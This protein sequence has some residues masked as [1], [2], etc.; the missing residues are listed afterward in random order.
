[1][2]LS[3]EDLLLEKQKLAE[4]VKEVNRQL[5]EI[6]VKV[7]DESESLK[8]FQR[9]R[10]EIDQEMDKGE[11]YSFVQENDLK[12]NILNEETLKARRLYKVKDNPYFG[13]IIFNNENL[14]IGIT[15][16]KRDMDY[17]V[18]DW[19]APISSLF[20]DYELGEATYTSP[21]GTE[22]GVITRKRQYR[23]EKGKLKH[24][25]DTNIN[26]DDEI[27]QEVLAETSSDKMKNIVNTIQAE[28]NA[29]I[30]DEKTKTIIV[31]GI[32]GSGK[33]SVALHRI[34]FLLYKI[35]YLTST[36]V[37]IFSPN[38]VFTEYISNV[39]PDL[40]EENTLQT[41]YHHFAASFISEYYRVESYSSFVER[42]YKGIRQDNDLIKYK[43]SDEMIP[44]MENYAK[45]YT[46]AARF[47]GD[48]EYK[49]TVIPLMELNEYLFE[50]YD[51]M[52][53]FERVELIAE[54]INNRYFKGTK[55]DYISILSRLYKVANFKKDFVAIYKN[56]FDS[57]IFQDSYKGNYRKNENM[58]NLA[59][60]VLNYEDASPFI[61]LKCLLE[62]Y[63]Y[64][65]YVRH[66][67]IDE[68]QD[69]TYL[70][71]KILA[72]IFKKAEFTIL[73]DTNQTVNP[74]YHYDSLK[75]LQNIFKTDSKYLELNKTYRSSP[76]IIEY[77][78]S[79]LGLNHVSAIRK[80]VNLPVIKRD[81]KDL[82]H[83][84][85]DIKYLKD[86]YKSVAVITKSIEE[87][88]LLAMELKKKYPKTSIIDIDTEKYN[89]ELVVAPA[90]G[91]KGL[92]FD[93]AIIINNF[94]SDTYLYY[95][96]VTRSQHELIVY[97]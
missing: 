69:Y 68:A 58:R 89:R 97:E 37:L 14:Y 59:K 75:V 64:K 33:T 3:K 93:S 12:I 83:I 18:M 53:L 77:A 62:G 52:P 27:L 24:V 7:T 50:R 1:M 2:N 43:L 87:A 19:R 29:I 20:Y 76:E 85:R 47:I 46:K 51:K 82:Q 74:Y 40:G 15:S 91:V 67:V 10:W 6:G 4:T 11:R 65:V 35:E 60:K 23:I 32:A 90:Y 79:V 21:G 5:D 44:A 45:Y 39:L 95:V 70:Q 9:L 28:Q 73:G 72:K 96:A 26:I 25:F 61:Y 84:G 56:F 94:S 92:E 49:E 63:P 78:N 42:Y 13:S 34:A 22:S 80:N 86:K 55:K 66:V 8:E 38:D 48:L 31:Q 36:N 57:L 54:K 16:I 71:Y 30:R 81:I 88:K 17:L 41:T